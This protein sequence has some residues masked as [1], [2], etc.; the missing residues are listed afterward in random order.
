MMQRVLLVDTLEQLTVISVPIRLDIIQKL[1]SKASSAKRLS[2]QFDDKSAQ[3]LNYHFSK[4]EK[5]GFIYKKYE[6]RIRGA[7]E[8][9]YQPVADLIRIDGRLFNQS[10]NDL[11][12]SF[13]GI[14][15]FNIDYVRTL[16]KEQKID[17]CISIVFESKKDLIEFI[18]TNTF[19]PTARFQL[20][21]INK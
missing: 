4:L 20:S 12:K 21:V 3:N 17:S 5:A 19:T 14:D 16:N 1:R 18:E 7:F 6:E 8:A 13:K 2:L 10:K 15:E 9:F 11:Y